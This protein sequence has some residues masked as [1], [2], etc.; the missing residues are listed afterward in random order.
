[1]LRT[2]LHGAL[3][4][5]MVALFSTVVDAA[6]VWMYPRGG[7]EICQDSDGWVVYTPDGSRHA[8]RTASLPLLERRYEI[9]TRGRVGPRSTG[10]RPCA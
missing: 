7:W 3:A 5:V 2:L 4:L 1:M 10:N 8:H 6:T 9:D